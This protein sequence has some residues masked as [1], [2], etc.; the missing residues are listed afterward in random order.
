L[1]SLLFRH[2]LWL[3]LF[4]AA[5][6]GC[7][8]RPQPMEPAELAPEDFS[9]SG[10]AEVRSRWW[11]SLDSAALDELIQQALNDNRS[12]RATR[13][14]LEQARA[15]A[16]RE[17]APRWPSLTASSEARRE[18]TDQDVTTEIFSGGASASWELDLWGRVDAAADAAALDAEARAAAWSDAA[19]TLTGEVANTWFRLREARLRAALLQD[20]L[21]V[22]KQVLKLI[23]LRRRQGQVGSA[24][25]LRQEQLVEQTRGQLI[26]TR[27]E[28]ER[29]RLQLAALVGTTPDRFQPPEASGDFP[30][31]PPE[32]DTGIPAEVLE[33]RPD[34]RQALLSVRAADE[35][36]AAAFAE[37]L[38]RIELGA[39]LTDTAVSA[40]DL[41]QDWVSTVSA[42]L[43]LPLI[44][45]GRRRAETDRAGAALRVAINDYEQ[46]MLDAIREVE[47]ALSAEQRQRER[48][49]SL[50]EQLDLAE[51]VLERIRSRYTRGATDYLDVLDALVSKQELE[52]QVLTARRELLQNRV[53]LHR[54]LAGGLDPEDYSP[55]TEP[56]PDE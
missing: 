12:L 53:T 26:G 21:A 49:A 42:S 22:N 3:T 35:R 7:Q 25:V 18:R 2:G 16:R 10:S 37:R 46:T 52:R 41:F 23:R 34:V 5:L 54:T 48:L 20:Q 45:G 30:S 9:A 55:R 29:L 6:A 15:V 19:I 1:P 4:L 24:D 28:S 32:P 47:D 36:V 31:A 44:D 40:G 51:Q 14:R 33:R 56:T 39:S 43:S 8:Q 11:R 27:R 38:P 13:A 50:R 17:G